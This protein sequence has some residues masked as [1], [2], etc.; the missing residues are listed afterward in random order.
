MT[1]QF[2]DNV[3]CAEFANESGQLSWVCLV[4]VI[5]GLSLLLHL[6]IQKEEKNIY[7]NHFYL[8]FTSSREM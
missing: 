1:S 8:I 4:I 3:L 5:S 6:Y 2:S 7:D